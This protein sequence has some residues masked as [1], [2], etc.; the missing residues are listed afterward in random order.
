MQLECSVKCLLL[1]HTTACLSLL[2][3]HHALPGHLCNRRPDVEKEK[4]IA[5]EM[6]VSVSASTKMKVGPAA[7][8]QLLQLL[9][10]ED[11]SLRISKEA[12]DDEAA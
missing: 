2:A 9:R 12:R 7:A 6:R 5:Q 3:N 11:P 8:R 4:E 1:R 10:C